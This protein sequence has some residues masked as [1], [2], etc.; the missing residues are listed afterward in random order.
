MERT[1]RMIK[2]YYKNKRR[3]DTMLR[4]AETQ[5]RRKEQIRRDIKECNIT[6]EI[7]STSIGYSDMPGATGG[8]PSSSIEVSLERSI[9]LLIRELE[10]TIRYSV[11]LETRIREI[12]EKIMNVEILLEDLEEEELKL[13][14]L[15]Y[16]DNK[17]YRF[18]ESELSMAIGTITNTKKRVLSKIKDEMNRR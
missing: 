1:E 11:R 3:L 2:S 8:L 10:N 16:R 13:L 15:I 9:D 4:K 7:P 18:I 17:R 14:E 6:I 12:E 5:R